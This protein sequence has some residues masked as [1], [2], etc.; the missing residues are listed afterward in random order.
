MKYSTLKT[1]IFASYW[2]SPLVQIS[3]LKIQKISFG[4]VDS[5]AKT[6]LILYPS[7]ENSTTPIAILLLSSINVTSEFSG[8]KQKTFYTPALTRWG[9]ILRTVGVASE[10]VQP[11]PL[12]FAGFCIDKKGKFVANLKLISALMYKY[13]ICLDS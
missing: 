9:I 7:L 6:I 10:P 3:N 8:I 1:V 12:S 11:R 5:Y 4:Y 2:G 13:W